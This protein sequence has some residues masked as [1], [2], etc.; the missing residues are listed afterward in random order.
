LN[1][2]GVSTRMLAASFACPVMP[3]ECAPFCNGAQRVDDRVAHSPLFAVAL[4]LALLE[5]MP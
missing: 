1:R 2:A 5:V 4:G 3:F